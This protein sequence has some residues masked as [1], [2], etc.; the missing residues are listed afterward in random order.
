M[1]FSLCVD[2]GGFSVMRKLGSSVVSPLSGRYKTGAKMALGKIIYPTFTGASFAFLLAVVDKAEL[3]SASQLLQFSTIFYITA[4]VLNALFSFGYYMSEDKDNFDDKV[5]N[6]WIIR[7]FS[8]LSQWSF[9][10]AT[11]ALVV[12]LIDIVLA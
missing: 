12:Y 11:S 2:F 7:R 3:I 10:C 1:A 5:T 6:C 8:S 9:I 4:L